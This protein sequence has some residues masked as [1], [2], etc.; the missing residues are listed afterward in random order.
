MAVDE[1]DRLVWDC[2]GDEEDR[3]GRKGEEKINTRAKPWH[4]F[5]VCSHPF[6][7][8]PRATPWL[9][10]KISPWQKHTEAPIL[11]DFTNLFANLR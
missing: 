4:C 7:K 11:P 8:R 9:R 2:A 6:A 3:P 10:V 1:D 5:S